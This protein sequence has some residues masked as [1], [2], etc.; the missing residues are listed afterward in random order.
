MQSLA[1]QFDG[2]DIYFQV[3]ASSPI[4]FLTVEEIEFHNIYKADL[5]APITLNDLKNINKIN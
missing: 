4:D 5:I 2:H 3:D 1:K